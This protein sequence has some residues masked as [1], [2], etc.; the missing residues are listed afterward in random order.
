MTADKIIAQAVKWIGKRESDGSHREIIDIYNSQKKL[1]RGYKVKYTDSWCA[2]F[3]SALSVKLGYTSIIPAECGCEKMIT[4]FKGLGCWIEDESIKPK[5][6]DII[7]YDWQ[8]STSGDNKG[9][10]DHVGIVEKVTNNTITVI[11]GNKSDAVGRRTLLVNAKYIRGYARPKYKTIKTDYTGHWAEKDIKEMI[12]KG[13]MVGDGNGI[14]RPN[15]NIT[16]AEI[17]KTIS[18]LLKYLGK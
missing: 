6:G 13:I 10:S 14:F 1:P 11:E 15:D 9:N 8:D 3:I 18:N 4:L 17:A 7:F 5:A 12:S 16:R 2:A